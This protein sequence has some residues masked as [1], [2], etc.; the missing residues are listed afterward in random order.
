MGVFRDAAIRGGGEWLH[1]PP[2]SVLERELVVRGSRV[3]LSLFDVPL[4]AEPV[5]I[6]LYRGS[7]AELV[8]FAR[9]AS[10]LSLA[11]NALGSS[12]V[13]RVVLV[14]ALLEDAWGNVAEVVGRGVWLGSYPL[15]NLGYMLGEPLDMPVL[16]DDASFEGVVLEC[17]ECSR[18]VCRAFGII[19]RAAGVL[20]GVVVEGKP[21]DV[22]DFLDEGRVVESSMQRG[23]R[24]RCVVDD[25]V[26]RIL[27][28]GCVF[29][30]LVLSALAGRESLGV[31]ERFAGKTG[32]GFC[33]AVYTLGFKRLF[34]LV[35]TRR[36][37]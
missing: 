2:I 3:A 29:E 12:R 26:C 30:K 20:K 1:P 4:E 9:L 31:V 14:S 32:L 21:I 25:G 23:A 10:L 11:V 36:V 35:V 37:V 13:L 28:D 16:E 34:D 18:S 5:N 33:E 22:D 8:C 17:G 15:W 24:V 27:S 7:A 6:L 19:L